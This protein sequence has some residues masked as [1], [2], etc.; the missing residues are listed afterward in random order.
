MAFGYFQ[1]VESRDRKGPGRQWPGSPYAQLAIPLSLIMVI[2]LVALQMP[3]HIHLGPL[4]VAAPALTA[5]FA[6]PGVTAAVGAVAVVVQVALRVI[7]GGLTL[8][9]GVIQVGALVI[10]TV[11]VVVYAAVRD[12]HRQEIAQVRLVSEA[13]QRVVLRPLPHRIGPL[14]IA[15]M[16]L[17]AT[18]EARVGG[19]LYAAVR[20]DGGTRL[21]IGDVSG[22]GLATIGDAAVLLYAFRRATHEY[23]KL[24]ELVSDLESSVA[25]N[26]AELAETDH[27]AREYFITAAIMHIPDD[28]PLIE[29]VACGHPPP[30]VLRGRKVIALQAERPAPP[31]G[32]G[33]LSGA[34]HQA[35][36]F[37]YELGD[38]LVL[39]TDGVIEARDAAGDFYPLAE[40][41]RTWYGL[42]PDDLVRAL[43]EDLVAFAGGRLDDD[44]ALVVIKREY[45]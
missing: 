17:A 36:T 12:R 18:A 37:S 43:R 41:I 22:K 8:T 15:S 39:Y 32:L 45:E 11:F 9:D 24:P 26:M 33:A 38:L 16:Y 4:L 30:L 27:N 42:D 3:R 13:A 25:R 7:R 35:E 40:R 1:V 23:A 28:L 5:S 20:V 2:A 10:V 29:V 44:A 31:L 21:I 6:G 19:D 14:R 34:D